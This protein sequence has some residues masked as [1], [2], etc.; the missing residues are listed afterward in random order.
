MPPGKP[1]S[2]TRHLGRD[3]QLR[4]GCLSIFI[5]LL[6]T[7]IISTSEYRPTFTTMSCGTKLLKLIALASAAMAAHAGNDRSGGGDQ[8]N[9][10]GLQCK[11]GSCHIEERN[12][13]NPTP[14]AALAGV[15]LLWPHSIYHAHLGDSAATEVRRKASKR[16]PIDREREEGR[17]ADRAHMRKWKTPYHFKEHTGG[18]SNASG[19]RDGGIRTHGCRS[20][21]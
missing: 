11:G 7:N 9:G 5:M 20:D 8:T 3:K 1:C 15:K 6:T 21:C 17:H 10:Q 12:G 14:A 13:S 2:R 18:C 4:T 19:C 16:E